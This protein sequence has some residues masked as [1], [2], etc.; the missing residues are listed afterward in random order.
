MS[1]VISELVDPSDEEASNNVLPGP[2][3]VPT[4]HESACS[5][6]S[7]SS[8]P[9]VVFT[10]SLAKKWKH[11]T[12]VCSQA[13]THGRRAGYTEERSHRIRRLLYLVKWFNY[14]K[15]A[16]PW[17]PTQMRLPKLK[18]SKLSK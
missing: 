6:D 15:F 2:I 10:S 5:A 9:S 7:I 13:S 14:Q 18:N 8:A 12:S 3:S 11:T 1:S 17:R 16:K 4:L